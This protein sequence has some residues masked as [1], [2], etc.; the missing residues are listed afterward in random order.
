MALPGREQTFAYEDCRDLRQKLDREIKRYRSMV[1]REDSDPEELKDTAFNASVT[2]WH[3]TD[4]VFNDLTP[5][6]RAS[7]RFED[8]SDL[9]EY[10]RTNCRALYLCRYAATASKHWE[11]TKHPDPNVQIVVT[12]ADTGWT[13]YFMDSGKRKAAEQVFDDALVF[14]TQFIYGHH[15]AQ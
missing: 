6:Q 12:L 8:L 10:A 4:W 9:Q 15:I 2:A 3:L 7:L 13:I 5:A 11:V 1:G 14:W